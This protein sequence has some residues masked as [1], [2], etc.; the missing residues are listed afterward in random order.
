MVF[1]SHQSSPGIGGLSPR[2]AVSPSYERPK[3][4]PVA[5]V[6]P[7]QHNISV[8][9]LHISGA[10]SGPHTVE[11]RLRI[12][13]RNRTRDDDSTRTHLSPRSHEAFTISD[14]SYP[15]ECVSSPGT[16][17]T[18]PPCAA[19]PTFNMSRLSKH[20]QHVMDALVRECTEVLFFPPQ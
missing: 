9:T 4:A 8:P 10:T 13:K 20:E 12:V 5:G 1:R 6:V 7:L 3:S 2:H 19:Y 16:A 14:F 15:N 18:A 17:G 11:D